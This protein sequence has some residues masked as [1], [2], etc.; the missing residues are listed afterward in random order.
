MGIENRVSYARTLALNRGHGARYEALQTRVSK[1]SV[2]T[3]RFEVPRNQC[4]SRI[5]KHFLAMLPKKSVRGG[6]QGMKKPIRNSFSD[7]REP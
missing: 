4:R 1:S 3:C 6:K 7:R 5:S 2:F